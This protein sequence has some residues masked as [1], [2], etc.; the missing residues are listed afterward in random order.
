M[1]TRIAREHQNDSRIHYCFWLRKIVTNERRNKYSSFCF[2]VL[3]IFIILLPRGRLS[4]TEASG[5]K[6]PIYLLRDHHTSWS[7]LSGFYQSTRN[8]S[9]PLIFMFLQGY[10]TRRS[11]GF[12]GGAVVESLPANAGDTGSRPGLGRSH[13]PRSN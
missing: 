5:I 12:P 10:D 7:I 6:L 1:P 9:S 8:K 11:Q 3:Q 4:K 2:G 13:M